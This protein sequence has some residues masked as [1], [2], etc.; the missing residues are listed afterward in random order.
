MTTPHPIEE[1]R[2]CSWCRGSGTAFS[3]GR[4]DLGRSYSDSESCRACEGTG[5]ELH[6][7]CAVSGLFGRCEAE[8]APTGGFQGPIFYVRQFTCLNGHRFDRTFNHDGHHIWFRTEDIAAHVEAV[9]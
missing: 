1:R 2:K 9:A 8:M 5:Y 3:Y 7:L 6:L 4:P